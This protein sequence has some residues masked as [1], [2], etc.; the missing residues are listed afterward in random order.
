MKHWSLWTFDR[1]KMQGQTQRKDACH[2]E[3]QLSFDSENPARSGGRRSNQK[4]QAERSRGCTIVPIYL[5]APDICLG[6]PVMTSHAVGGWHLC[7]RWPTN[8][9]PFRLFYS[10]VSACSLSGILCGL[11]SNEMILKRQRDG[12]VGEQSNPGMVL[13]FFV[14]SRASRKRVILSIQES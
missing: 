8:T 10:Q 6:S 4:P 3:R 11:P 7:F 13:R 14:L 2:V 9:P 12:N 1:Q 5:V